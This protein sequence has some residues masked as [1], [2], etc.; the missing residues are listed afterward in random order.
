MS[1]VCLFIHVET[2]IF[3]GTGHKLGLQGDCL[4]LQACQNWEFELINL[5]LK[6]LDSEVIPTLVLNRC[7]SGANSTEGRV[8]RH[9]A[10]VH[11]CEQVQLT[12]IKIMK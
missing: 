8:M 10:T 3:Q 12:E 7:K 1:P 11:V 6:G 9:K 4:L 5:S 2:Y